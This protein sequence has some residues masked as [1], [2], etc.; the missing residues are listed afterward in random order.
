MMTTTEPVR[1]KGRGEE[2]ASR[3]RLVIAGSGAADKADKP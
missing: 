3:Y 1:I 2:K